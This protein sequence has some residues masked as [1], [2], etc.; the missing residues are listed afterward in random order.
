M[1][2][3]LL[4]NEIRKVIYPYKM[5]SKSARLL[6]REL[7]NFRVFKDRKYRPQNRD[8]IINWGSS[9]KPSWES[10][11]VGSKNIL[12][13]PENVRLATNKLTALRVLQNRGVPT[14][15]FTTEYREAVKWMETSKVYSRTILNGHSG[16]GVA[17]SDGSV[18]PARL[19]TKGVDTLAEYRVHIFD[20]AVIDYTK[21]RR[22]NGEPATPAQLL[23]RS[24]K[25]GW[26]FTRGNLRRLHKVEKLAQSAVAAL[27]LDFGA[28]DIVKDRNRN[29]FV[30][31]VNTAVG[32]API[33]LENYKNAVT[34]H[35]ATTHTR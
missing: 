16:R 29:V 13:K 15:E 2:H 23:V 25:N 30:L 18:T 22:R 19:Y 7:S 32:L 5:G 8:E 20:G 9:G 14:V 24:L 21:K 12:N 31:E 10:R 27:G 1:P 26:I 6:A 34:K 4:R 35:Y 3:F 17:V 28:V 11:L 33:T